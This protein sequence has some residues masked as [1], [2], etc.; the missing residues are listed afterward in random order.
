MSV[1]DAER[2]KI[3]EQ[4]YSLG[5]ITGI[6]QAADTLNSKAI[7][8]FSIRNDER[9]IVLRNLSDELIEKAKALRVEYNKIEKI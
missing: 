1:T 2:L 5:V 9:A 4:N 6:Q 3:E 7:Y 8:E